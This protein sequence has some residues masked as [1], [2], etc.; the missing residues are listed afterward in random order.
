MKRDI[1]MGKVMVKKANLL[2]VLHY[3]SE[4]IL[5][6]EEDIDIPG[7]R[8]SSSIRPHNFSFIFRSEGLNHLDN[9][10]AN[11]S[12]FG[13]RNALFK[14]FHMLQS[15]PLIIIKVNQAGPNFFL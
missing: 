8:L 14:I 10:I 12:H 11:M 9:I 5:S 3:L 1:A 7:I 15:Y 13:S 2:K 4:H 6:G